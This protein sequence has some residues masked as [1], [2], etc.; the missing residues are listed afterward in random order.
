MTAKAS[1]M[2]SR[3]VRVAQRLSTSGAAA[4]ALQLPALPLPPALTTGPVSGV[5]GPAIWRVR[6]PAA[7]LSVVG[8]M[9][10]GVAVVEMGAGVAVVCV[11]AA[12]T[13]TPSI[14]GPPLSLLRGRPSA[15][16]RALPRRRGSSPPAATAGSRASACQNRLPSSQEARLGTE[17][18]RLG[19]QGCAA[20]PPPR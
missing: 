18:K 16:A 11:A 12:L 4:E 20:L 14:C 2:R 3:A 13:T 5:P 15:V 17:Y 8:D 19:P 10:A 6:C 9:G 7:R 1:A